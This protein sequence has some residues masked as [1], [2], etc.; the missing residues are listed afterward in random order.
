MSIGIFGDSFAKCKVPLMH[1]L[2]PSNIITVKH[3]HDE[4]DNFQQKVEALMPTWTKLLPDTTN[5]AAGGTD[6][7]WSFLKF[8][9]HHEKYDNIIFVITSPKRITLNAPHMYVPADRGSKLGVNLI[10]AVSANQSLLKKEKFDNFVEEHLYIRDAY[11]AINKWQTHIQP[12]FP[13]RDFLHYG[14]LINELQRIRP[15]IKLIKAFCHPTIDDQQVSSDA[16]IEEFSKK[17]Y[18]PYKH[19]D[20]IPLDNKAQYLHNIVKAENSNY[21]EEQIAQPNKWHD[22]R[23]GH[24]SIT[25]HVILYKIITKWLK[26]N[27]TWLNFDIEEFKNNKVDANDSFMDRSKSL[28]EWQDAFLQRRINDGKINGR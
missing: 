5:F 15:D 6:L 14:I 19:F 2:D 11:D 21:F 22:C 3:T 12:E 18:Y 28:P 16:K 26:T 27:D 25:S 1:P 13:E 20:N 4:Y 8:L 24:I 7:S 17:N 10:T 23:A 9:E